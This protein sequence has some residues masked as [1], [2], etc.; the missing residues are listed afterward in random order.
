MTDTQPKPKKRA[1]HRGVAKTCDCAPRQ[2]LRCEH[3]YYLAFRY[4]GGKH[5]RLSLDKIA[6]RHLGRSE[7]LALAD[8]LRAK[9]RRGEYSTAPE[10]P[11][12][13]AATTDAVAFAELGRL[14]IAREREGRVADWKGDRSRLDRLGAVVI[15]ATELLAHRAIGRLTAD[16]LELAF[17]FVG[18]GLTGQTLNKYLQTVQQ[19]QRWG[20]RKGYM[21]RAWFDAEN[22]P[23]N[24]AKVARR[25]R[26]LAPE[27]IGADGQTVEASEEQRLIKAAGPWLQRLIIAALETGCRRGELLGLQWRH[28]DMSRGRL[29]VPREITKT[30]EGRTVVMSARLRSVLDMVRTNPVNGEAHG[31]LAYVFGDAQGR[32]VASPKKAWEVCVL[33]AHGH[34]PIWRK[35]ANG[36]AAESRALLAAIDLHW[37]DLRH[38]AGSRWIEAGWPLHHVQRMLGHADLKQTSTYLNATVT[39]IEESM[40]KLDE[41]RGFLQSVAGERPIAPRLERNDTEAPGDNSLIN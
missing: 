31:P 34:R 29:N 23:T 27:V 30:D 41:Q 4:R 20:V 17:R 16:D 7:A 37:H 13:P 2:W 5:W 38:E 12:K 11:A 21:T 3:S 40:R 14:W 22:R 25:T 24:R 15:E 18:Q 33:K 19:L 26:R 32:R 10:A 6:S 36:L 35:G 8:E 28:V 39:G 1:R 9:I